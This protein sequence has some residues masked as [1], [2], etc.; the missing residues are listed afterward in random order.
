MLTISHEQVLARWDTL[1]E[2]IREAIFSDV[3]ADTLWRVCET[4]HLSE[5][6]TQR[7]ATVAGDVLMGFLHPSSQDVTEE[8]SDRIAIPKQVAAVLAEELYRKIFAPLRDDLDRIYSPIPERVVQPSPLPSAERIPIK[9]STETL[10]TAP[11]PSPPINKERVLTTQLP[12]AE[13]KN[14]NESEMKK[15]GTKP[16]SYDSSTPPVVKEVEPFI[17]HE[18][19][20]FVSPVMSRTKPSV[21]FDAPSFPKSSS[22]STKPIVARVETPTSTNNE[23]NVRVV[24]YSNLR[25]PL[26][27][28]KTTS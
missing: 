16:E 10:T 19:K 9:D 20:E 15:S 11:P 28:K 2:N 14:K 3:N 1:P 21:S 22:F 25:T 13:I 4:N 7:V 17:L 24:H 12:I 5:E 6:R 8:I 27:D 18:E 26:D 23:D